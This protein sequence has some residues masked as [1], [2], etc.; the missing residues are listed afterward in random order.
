MDME[1]FEMF[2]FFYEEGEE[3]EEEFW[4]DNE[5]NEEMFLEV[6]SLRVFVE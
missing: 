2:C 6:D 4:V 5:G 3:E 1:E